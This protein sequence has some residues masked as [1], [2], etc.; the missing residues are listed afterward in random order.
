MKG[1]SSFKIFGSEY[2][3]SSV[4]MNVRCGKSYLLVLLPVLAFISLI[5]NGTVLRHISG[6]HLNLRVVDLSHPDLDDAPFTQAELVQPEVPYI[7]SDHF[8]QLAA[9]IRNVTAQKSKALL[10]QLKRNS[11]VGTRKKLKKG[12]KRRRKRR[13]RRAVKTLSSPARVPAV[14]IQPTSSALATSANFSACLLIK[15]DNAILNEWIAYHYHVL[16]MRR[17]I[18]AVDPL[19]SES[20][21]SILDKWSSLTDL[22][23]SQWSD[24]SYMPD[25]F[26]ENG[27][28]RDEFMQ[29]QSDFDQEMTQQQILE[30]SNH[31][32]RQRVFFAKCMRDLRDRGSS[33]VIH[34]DT[35]EY[36]VPSKLLREVAPSGLTIPSIE[37][38]GSVL[39]FVQQVVSRRLGNYP[40]I[41]LLRLLFGS[42]ESS[43]EERTEQVP[44]EFDAKNFETLRWRYHANPQNMKLHGS[45]K[46]IIDVSSI[47]EEFLPK[48]VVYSIHRPVE[49]FCQRN[50]DLKYDNFLSQSIAANHYL[51]SWER[52]SAR[53]DN[54]RSKETYENKAHLKHAADDGVRPWLT[55]FV[56]FVGLDL[57]SEL[58]GD[59][60]LAATPR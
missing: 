8:D 29:D 42:I 45:P 17:L 28:P 44:P 25:Y 31:R 2:C 59:T 60:Y 38:P 35:D 21:K 46:T 54:R 15:D 13:K 20:P 33:W 47:P 1:T 19:S 16:R 3:E 37:E 57:A 43:E 53:A 39:T 51:G 18:V 50:K 9:K 48:E 41:S 4:T 7:D 32:Y 56:E 5:V 36:V 55:G 30:I 6:N 24:E 40:C 14:A 12:K 11:K 10:S 22:E 23:I 27:R 49:Q 34:I 52:Y 26:L 58:L